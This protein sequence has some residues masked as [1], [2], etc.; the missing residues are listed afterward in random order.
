MT[1][2]RAG[3]DIRPRR[4]IFLFSK[5]SKLPER[6]THP[7]IQQDLG[8]HSMGVKQPVN[9]V[10][11]SVPLMAYVT[12]EKSMSGLASSSVP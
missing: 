11:H 6:P 7:A 1:K 4:E 12:S 2:L 9:E 3:H 10:G 8:V 5:A